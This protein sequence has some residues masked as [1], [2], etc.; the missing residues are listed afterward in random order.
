MILT[1]FKN[2][3]DRLSVADAYQ[4]LISLL[5]NDLYARNKASGSLG[6]AVN[7][8]TIFLDNNGY[9]ERIR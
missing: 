8:G 5:A 6:G 7:G 2:V 1:V 3:G 4:K 9:Y